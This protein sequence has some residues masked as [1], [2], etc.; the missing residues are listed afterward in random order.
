MDGSSLRARVEDGLDALTNPHKSRVDGRVRGAFADSLDLDA[1]LRAQ[2]PSDNRW[3]YLLGY[4]PS[5]S[6]IGLEPHS[7]KHDQVSTVIA[8]RRAALEH[9]RDHLKP[10][11]RIARWLWVASGRVDFADTEKTRLT[12]DQNGITFI[13]RRVLAK[14]LKV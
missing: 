5:R 2:Y 6:V 11:A 4:G 13:G 7:A 3:D 9:L 12:L 14:H 10:G 1:A 8:K